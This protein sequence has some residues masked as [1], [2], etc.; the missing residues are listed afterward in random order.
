VDTTYLDLNL[1]PDPDT[2]PQL[3]NSIWTRSR[4]VQVG[5]LFTHEVDL[6]SDTGGAV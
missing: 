4:S 5:Q 3:D 2:Y 1:D 6:Y